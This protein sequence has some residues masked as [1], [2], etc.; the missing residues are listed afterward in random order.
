MALLTT[1]KG[2][3]NSIKACLDRGLKNGRVKEY[4]RCVYH[5][6]RKKEPAINGSLT[7]CGE[8]GMPQINTMAV[9]NAMLCKKV[10]AS[11]GKIVTPKMPI[12][13]VDGLLQAKIQR[14]TSLE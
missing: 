8:T 12:P 13:G 1:L 4:Y 3:L 2:R 9:P 5:R 11:G 14:A 10:A 7:K 6:Q